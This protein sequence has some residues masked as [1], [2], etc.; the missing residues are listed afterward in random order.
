MAQLTYY[1]T[2][3]P[4]RSWWSTEKPEPG[5]DWHPI[6]LRHGYTIRDVNAA[7]RIGLK[8]TSTTGFSPGERYEIAWSSTI[9][10]LY[11]ADPRPEFIDLIAA[12]SRAIRDTVRAN[13]KHHG[14]PDPNSNTTG[15][16]HAIYW[17]RVD[18]PAIDRLDELF[19]IHQVWFA[20]SDAD[21]ET[22]G[23]MAAAGTARAAA[24]L[25][26]STYAAYS[27][28]LKAARKRAADIWMDGLTVPSWMTDGRVRHPS[29]RPERTHCDAGHEYT[30]ENTREPKPGSGQGRQCRA[31]N[32]RRD[33]ERRS[34]RRA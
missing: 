15:V 30:P 2:P 13:N 29:G 22:L 12:A 23:A 11:E 14:R 20:L 31:C 3:G 18:I 4:A 7:V 28:R 21:R 19:A 32:R 33:A 1:E 6:E 17:T 8:R 26:G 16:G 5:T 10:A 24:R 34:R 25:V 9:L 27:Q